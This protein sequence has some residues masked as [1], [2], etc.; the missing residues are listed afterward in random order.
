MSLGGSKILQAYSLT[1][2]EGDLMVISSLTHTARLYPYMIL[3]LPMLDLKSN[4]GSV[5]HDD[6]SSI[7]NSKC[8]ASLPAFLVDPNP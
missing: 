4:A 5:V 1:V 7:Q 2:G 6:N 3:S 8:F